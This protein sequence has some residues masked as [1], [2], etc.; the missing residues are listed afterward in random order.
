MLIKMKQIAC[1]VKQDH[2]YNAI[3]SQLYQTSKN[4]KLQECAQLK[5]SIYMHQSNA[6][7]AVHFMLYIIDLKYSWCSKSEDNKD[8]MLSDSESQLGYI[9]VPSVTQGLQQ[10]QKA[11]VGLSEAQ[12]LQTNGIC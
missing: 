2:F 11:E 12:E 3:K 9:T 10:G 1:E 7:D 5:E 6:A 8:S 4:P